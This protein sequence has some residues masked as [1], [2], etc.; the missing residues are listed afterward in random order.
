[1]GEIVREDRGGGRSGEKIEFDEQLPGSEVD[2]I[3]WRIRLPSVADSHAV[4][5]HVHVVGVELGGRRADRGENPMKLDSAAPKGSLR[6]FT[7]NETRFQML[8][9]IDPERSAMLQQM[10]AESVK[11]RFARYQQ[12]A[13]IKPPVDPESPNA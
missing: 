13:A 5:A 2:P 7:R 10:A 1:M 3:A 6:D 4:H 12:L 9:R 8:E 11:E